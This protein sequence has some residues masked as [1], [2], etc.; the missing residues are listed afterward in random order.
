MDTI[1]DKLIEGLKNGDQKVFNSIFEAYYA[2]LCRYCTRIV[3]D[4]VM[5]EEI[6]QDL[7]CK[8]WI[9]REEI[10]IN[11][12]LKSYLYK[13]TMNHSINHLAHIKTEEKYRQ[14]IGF[15]VNESLDYPL[16]I[17]NEK[18]VKRVLSLALHQMPDKRR[19]IFEMSR[20]EDMKYHEIAEKLNISVKT[21]ESQMAKALEYLR[22]IFSDVLGIFFPLV[23]SSEI[24]GNEIIKT[25][26]QAVI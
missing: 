17:L 7:F 16:D 19:M 14:F 5:A 6:V 26:I 18:D 21:V 12:S 20:Y 22:K 4:S 8:I 23:I 3:Y 13:A 15:N 1:Q 24:I 10:E 25:G 2:P 11:S 9:K